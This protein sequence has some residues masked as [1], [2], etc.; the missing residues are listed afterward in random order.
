MVEG[1]GFRVRVSTA[2]GAVEEAPKAN[3]PPAGAAPPNANLR[4]KGVHAGLHKGL[5]QSLHQSLGFT[6]KFALGFRV[7]GL[8][9]KVSGFGFGVPRHRTR[10]YI[11]GYSKVGIRV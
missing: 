7:W 3:A 1:P 10:T 6:S 11:R 4:Y 8:G 2:G 5:H 9:F